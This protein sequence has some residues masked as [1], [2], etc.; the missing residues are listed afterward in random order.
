MDAPI[1]E[2]HLRRNK[3]RSET[4]KEHKDLKTIE[5]LPR[6]EVKLKRSAA[7]DISAAAR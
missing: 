7:S 3:K 2:R 1:A 6:E 5:E 4:R